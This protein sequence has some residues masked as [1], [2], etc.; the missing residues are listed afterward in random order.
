MHRQAS[1][2]YQRTRQRVAEKSTLVRSET[3]DEQHI[4]K[5]RQMIMMLVEEK[6]KPFYL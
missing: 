6:R 1:F 3:L 4:S 2:E 5:K